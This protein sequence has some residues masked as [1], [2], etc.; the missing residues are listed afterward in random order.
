MPVNPFIRLFEAPVETLTLTAY[1]LGLVTL[2]VLTAGFVW[3]NGLHVYT[4]FHRPRRE[5]TYVPPLTFLL[6]VAAIPFVLMWDAW[7]LAA[8]ITYLA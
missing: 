7:A 4:E 2:L 5:W 6:R 8:I 3:S 1:L